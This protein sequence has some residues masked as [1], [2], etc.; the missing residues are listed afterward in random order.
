MVIKLLFRLGD[1]KRQVVSQWSLKQKSKDNHLNLGIF[2]RWCSCFLCYFL[3]FTIFTIRNATTWL[4]CMFEVC[5]VCFKALVRGYVSYVRSWFVICCQ[6]MSCIL[7]GVCPQVLLR[8]GGFG[9]LELYLSK[10]DIPLW[11]PLY[12]LGSV[13]W[14]NK[15]KFSLV[16]LLIS[17][18]CNFS[19]LLVY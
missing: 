12:I 10:Y 4:N 5:F 3:R 14:C 15:L 18:P 19:I 13:S 7:L 8:L 2:I 16:D 6:F 1:G 17:C 11:H 9:M